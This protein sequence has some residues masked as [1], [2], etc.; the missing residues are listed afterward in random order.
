MREQSLKRQADC[1]EQEYRN[2]TMASFA[3]EFGVTTLPSSVSQGVADC[4]GCD[5]DAE[6]ERDDI[7]NDMENGSVPSR[8][9]IDG[10]P[11]HHD[12]LISPEVC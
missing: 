8:T 5:D 11:I 9:S 6:G 4:S 7:V 12:H 10:L 2:K 3:S 1:R